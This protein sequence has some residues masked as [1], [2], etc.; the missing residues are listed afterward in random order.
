MVAFASAT[1]AR[2]CDTDL[3]DVP[4]DREICS[5]PMGNLK[6]RGDVDANVERGAAVFAQIH[7]AH[8]VLST[9]PAWAMKGPEGGQLPAM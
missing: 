3:S 7:H 9:M 1:F 5:R 8:L 4:R 6:I 2:Q